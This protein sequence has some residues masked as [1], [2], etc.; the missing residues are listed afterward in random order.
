[1]S[2]FELFRAASMLQREEFGGDTTTSQVSFTLRRDTRDDIR[3][4]NRG[5]LS[6]VALEYAGLGGVNDFLRLEAR[7][8]HWLP[9]RWLPFEATFVINGRIGW[10]LPFNSIA[11]FD[12]PP[13]G[14]DLA[15]PNSCASFA[16]RSPDFAGLAQIDDDLE[17]PLTERYFLGGLGNFQLRGY[18]Q[19]AVGPRR[20]VLASQRGFTNPRDRAFTTF[21]LNRQT[22]DCTI[23]EGCNSLADK[24]DDDFVDL[25]E[26]D[27]IGGNKM[28]LLN[29]ELQFPISEELGLKG[30]VFTDMGNAYAEDEG[31]D[32]SNLRFGAGG[33]VQWFSPFGPITIILGIPI[34]KLE[35]EDASVFEFSMGGSTF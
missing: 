10:A 6:G 3:F 18:K 19:R 35:D 17:L 33:G 27:V 11:D 4:P 21:G 1:M 34:N 26:T 2:S 8:S 32:L 31:F 16:A 7:S 20:A 25:D 12:L 9:I 5:Q 29:L 14:G 30:L 15:D 23:P 13:C 24:E 28:L 22:G